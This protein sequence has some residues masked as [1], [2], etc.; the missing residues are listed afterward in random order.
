MSLT[1]ERGGG[2]VKP[3]LPVADLTSGLWVA[4]AILAGAAG[5]RATGQ[6]QLHRLLDDRR[7]RWRCS[8]SPR[9][10][11]S[12]SAKCRR[13]SAPSIPAACRPRASAAPDG[14]W[15]HITASDQHWLPLCR[16]LGL[17]QWGSE[18]GLARELRPRA[19]ARGGDGEAD[20]RRSATRQPRRARRRVRRRRRSGRADQGGRR[21]ARRPAHARA[22]HGR[23]LRAPDDRRVPVPAGAAQVRRLGRPA[24][25]PS[26]AARRAHRACSAERLGYSR[27]ADCG[28]RGRRRRYERAGPAT[29]STTASRRSRSTGRRAATRST[30]RCAKGC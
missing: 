21:G 17:E 10:A 13:A 5:P 8:R 7:R 1:G 30:A 3:G 9:R 28:A 16:V 14:G 18:P 12:R 6:G 25:R 27:R 11:G 24:G 26:A 20:R 19:P 2:P 4:I 23:E 29:P 15:L 22:R